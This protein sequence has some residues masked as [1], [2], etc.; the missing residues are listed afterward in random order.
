MKTATL[1]I[2]IGQ[3]K[4]MFNPSNEVK[5]HYTIN[6]KYKSTESLMK[7]I[8]KTTTKINYFLKSHSNTVVFSLN[9]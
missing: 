2:S 8:K 6:F 5:Q 7:K 1:I 4:A 9:K 3:E